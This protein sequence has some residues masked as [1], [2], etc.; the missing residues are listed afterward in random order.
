MSW[1]NNIIKSLCTIPEPYIN[2]KYISAIKNHY[3]KF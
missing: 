2:K 1:D 3:K